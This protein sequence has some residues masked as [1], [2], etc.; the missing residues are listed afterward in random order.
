MLK[1][2]VLLLTI[3]LVFIVQILAQTN[4]RPI[5]YDEAIVAAKTEGKY[6]FIDFYTDW[7]APCKMM[8][9]DVFPQ[10]EVGE[11]MNKKFVCIQLNAEKEGKELADLFQVKAY[12]T[13]IV[14]DINKKVIMKKE[15]GSSPEKFIAAIDREIDPEKS[16]ERLKERYDGGERTPELIKAY[17]N[18]KVSEIRDQDEAREEVAVIISDYFNGISDADRLSPKN[19]FIYVN[20]V[21]SPSDPIA[22]Y[23]VRHRNDFDPTIRDTV[24]KCISE[25]YKQEVFN[26]LCAGIPYNESDYQSVKKTINEL[27]MNLSHCYDSSFELIEC[28]SKGDLDAFLTLCEKKYSDL[29]NDQKF[30]LMA[31]FSKLMD[32]DD[33]ELRLRAAKF[34]RGKLPEMEVRLLF[35]IARV[36][37]ELEME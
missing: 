8:A 10:E 24:M 34:V 9:R 25:M 4:F 28:H 13:F 22:Q 12:P 31:A 29:D 35:F 6:V 14:T 33:K 27:G 36:L 21:E 5:A 30:Y 11:Y 2:I 26:Y 17:V 16:P 1:K 32:T 18:W 37:S 20:Y 19:L 7:C 23:M 3:I 15:G